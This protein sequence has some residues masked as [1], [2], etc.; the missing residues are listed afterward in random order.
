MS[1]VGLRNNELDFA[2]K[3][4]DLVTANLSVDEVAAKM[5]WFVFRC[6]YIN[7]ESALMALPN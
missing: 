5:N 7:R 4:T 1:Y 6:V 3:N 2:N